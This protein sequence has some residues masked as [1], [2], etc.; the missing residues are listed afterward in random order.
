M[1]LKNIIQE[2]LILLYYIYT[3]Y[4]DLIV[5]QFLHPEAWIVLT[6]LEDAQHDEQ[7]VHAVATPTTA[8]L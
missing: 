2:F 4:T 5:L 8:G 6:D 7:E 3:I 1:I